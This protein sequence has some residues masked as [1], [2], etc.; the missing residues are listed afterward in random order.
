MPVAQAPPSLPP[1][2]SFPTLLTL[3]HPVLKSLGVNSYRFSLAWS[4]IIPN[5]GKDD[6]V[7]E[8]GIKFYSDLIDELIKNAITPFVVCLLFVRNGLG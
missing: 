1:L 3:R 6:P 8:Q 2:P 7:N 4:R 5:G